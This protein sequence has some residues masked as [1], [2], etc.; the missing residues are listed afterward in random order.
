MQLPDP[1][2][3]DDIA[4]ATRYAFDVT[5]VDEQDFE[6]T[7]LEDLEER[8]PVDASRLH[9]DGVDAADVEPVDERVEV[10]GEALEL[11]HRLIVAILGHGNPVAGRAYID[12]CRVEVDPLEELR[13]SVPSVPTILLRGFGPAL[14]GSLPWLC[15]KRRSI[16]GQ[17]CV[18]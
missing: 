7:L 2:A 8:D 1:L 11:A 3:I 5:C 10:R 9:G 17:G 6:V 12:A 18:S 15:D 16:E 4:L 14:H 13:H